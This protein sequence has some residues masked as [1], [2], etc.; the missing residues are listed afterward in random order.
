MPRSDANESAHSSWAMVPFVSAK[1]RHP[2]LSSRVAII[3]PPWTKMGD[4]PHVEG[5][6]RPLL[7]LRSR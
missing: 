7:C 4:F 5:L 3:D 2:V 6:R 1:R